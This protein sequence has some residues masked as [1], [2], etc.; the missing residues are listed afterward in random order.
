MTDTRTKW[1][2]GSLAVLT[3][4]W[5]FLLSVSFMLAL[6]IGAADAV[7][8]GDGLPV[9]PGA[10]WAVLSLGLALFVVTNTIRIQHRLLGRFSTR[11]NY[12]VLAVLLVLTL[13]LMPMPFTY[14]NF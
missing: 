11:T 14:T 9:W 8:P 13:V 12:I 7:F 10:I 4:W 1:L 5:T 6:T 3:A 2:R